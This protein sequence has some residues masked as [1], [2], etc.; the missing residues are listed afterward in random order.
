LRWA[1]LKK[2]QEQKVERWKKKENEKSFLSCSYRTVSVVWS[3]R[4][5]MINQKSFHSLFW[6][7]IT[8]ECPI[9][10]TSNK[11][12]NFGTRR[13]P[14]IESPT[15]CFLWQIHHGMIFS[16]YFDDQLVCID[17]R[18]FNTMSRQSFVKEFSLIVGWT[19]M[20][21]RNQSLGQKEKWNLITW[22][23]NMVLILSIYLKNYI[24]HNY[25]NKL[26]FLM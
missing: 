9:A 18:P 2:Y 11:L 10:S 1:E 3:G 23:T 5:V 7:G 20:G 4:F 16:I 25:D 26:L 6:I 17:K 22:N 12:S 19:S 13:L 8:I 24:I 14:K 15:H 21:P